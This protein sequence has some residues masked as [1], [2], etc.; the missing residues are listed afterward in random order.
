[1]A[2]RKMASW[3][4]HERRLLA[5][6][7]ITWKSNSAARPHDDVAKLVK[8]DLLAH[9]AI[10]EPGQLQLLCASIISVTSSA[11]V[12][13]APVCVADRLRPQSDGQVTL[14]CACFTDQNDWFLAL[15]ILALAQLFLIWPRRSAALPGKSNSSSV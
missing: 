6:P 9:P 8:D 10:A 12:V 1:V 4:L 11:A 13:S 14:A 7:A 2:I 3:L 15:Q 5:R